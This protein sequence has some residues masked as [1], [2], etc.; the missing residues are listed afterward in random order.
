MEA[1]D[2][3]LLLLDAEQVIYETLPPSSR[4]LVNQAIFVALI[5]CDPDTI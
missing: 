1:L 5:V 4:R 3:A 2:N